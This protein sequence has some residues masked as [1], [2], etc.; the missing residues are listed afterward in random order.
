MLDH[1]DLT[2]VS[3]VA[4]DV[5]GTL[6]GPDSLVNDRTIAAMTAVVERGIPVIVLTGRT[7]QNTLDI[8]RRAGVQHFAA[9]CNGALVFDPITNTDQSVTPMSAGDKNAF[10]TMADTLG[11]D[12]TW[13]TADTIFVARQGPMAEL[14]QVLN[15]ETA[16]VADADQIDELSVMKMMAYGPAV[17]MDRIEPEILRMFPNAARS[18][19]SLVEGVNP[20]A[21]KWHALQWILNR[22][23]LESA[24]VLG[25][26][27][28]GN[29][30]IWLAEIGHPVAMGNARPEVK[31]IALA[32]APDHGDDGVAVLLER[33]LDVQRAR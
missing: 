11:L 33:L 32:E 26:G 22:Y 10:R 13:W 9:A 2:A 21:T 31:A 17:H 1:L 18:L 19:D 16:T 24:G 15:H 6:A 8:A 3:A 5:D 14:I 4:L 20:E 27:D 28:G 7:R 29:D 30:V 23:G 25:M 12:L